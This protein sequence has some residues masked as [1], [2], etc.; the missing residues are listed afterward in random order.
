MIERQLSTDPLVS[1]T[2]F[3]PDVYEPRLLSAALE[4]DRY[5]PSVT[6]ARL[7]SRWFESGDVSSHYVET[8]ADEPNWQCRWDRHPNGYDDRLHFH[9]PPDG[10]DTVDLDRPSLHP[11]DVYA[12]VL[13][14]IETRIE[15]TWDA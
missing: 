12:T 15:P 8:R 4:S 9:R 14:A 1:T 5:P 11:L 7:D 6:A 13:A 10:T 2:Q 3:D